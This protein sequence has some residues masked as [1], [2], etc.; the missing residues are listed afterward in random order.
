MTSGSA[1][2]ITILHAYALTFSNPS[3]KVACCGVCWLHELCRGNQMSEC[4]SAL[5]RLTYKATVLKESY[6]SLL[7]APHCSTGSMTEH[8]PSSN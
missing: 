3:L 2:Y 6:L 1:L 4:S 7:S 8:N 5:Q